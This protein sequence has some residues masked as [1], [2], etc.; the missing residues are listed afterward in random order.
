MSVDD[1]IASAHRFLAAV[2]R[3]DAAGVGAELHADAVAVA[4]GT[5]ALSGTRSRDEVVGT[6]AMLGQ[7]I[8]D[9]ITFTPMDVTAQDDRVVISATGASTTVAGTPYNN[10]YCFVFFFVDGKI[11]RVLEMFDTK[12]ADE[13]FLPLMAG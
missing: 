6:V 2:G 5:S 9:G 12:L 11:I 10:D 8:P 7:L 1:H 3:A 4:R 13:T